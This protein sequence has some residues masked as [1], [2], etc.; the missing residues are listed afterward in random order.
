MRKLDQTFH[1]IYKVDESTDLYMIEVAL[2][3]YTDIFSEW[4]P[5]PFK[6]RALDPD[7]DHYLEESSEEIPFKYPIELCLTLPSS[8]WDEDLESKAREGLANSF[9][10]SRYLIKKELKK[11]NVKIAQFVLIGLLFLWFAD[12]YS[13]LFAQADWRSVLFE[14]LA[15]SGWVFVWEAVSLFVFSNRDLAHR[16][17]TYKRLENAPVIFRKAKN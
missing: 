10:F 17:R 15:I 11:T 16:Y 9:I 13:N 4:D 14:G 7:L 6:R 3:N 2:D 12:L 1:E 8:M 5:A